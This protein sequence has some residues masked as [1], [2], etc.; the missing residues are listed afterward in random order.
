MLHV[1]EHVLIGLAIRGQGLDA[2]AYK[3]FLTGGPLPSPS[4]SYYCNECRAAFTALM[5]TRRCPEGHEVKE[6]V[7]CTVVETADGVVYPAHSV[8]LSPLPENFPRT[9]PPAT[10]APDRY[11]TDQGWPDPGGPASSFDVSF[12]SY[13]AALWRVGA[14]ASSGG[15]PPPDAVLLVRTFYNAAGL[16]EDVHT[17]FMNYCSACAGS[18]PDGQ[19]RVFGAALAWAQWA[20]SDVVGPM[21]GRRYGSLPYETRQRIHDWVLR[22]DRR[23][24]VIQR[25]PP[26]VTGEE[27]VTRSQRA[28][29]SQY[30]QEPLTS[31]TEER[32]PAV[33]SY[34]RFLDDVNAHAGHFSAPSLFIAF[35]RAFLEQLADLTRSPSGTV[36]RLVHASSTYQHYHEGEIV[37][38]L[39]LHGELSFFVRMLVRMWGDSPAV[40][41]GV[42]GASR[43]A[44]AYGAAHALAINRIPCDSV[45]DGAGSSPLNTD[46]VRA[47]VGRHM[48]FWFECGF[49]DQ[50]D[51]SCLTL[52]RCPHPG[53]DVPTAG[54]ACYP[55]NLTT[56][57]RLV[58]DGYVLG[59]LHK[60]MSDQDDQV[61]INTIHYASFLEEFTADYGHAHLVENLIAASQSRDNN[62]RD[63]QLY[64]MAQR[65]YMLAFAGQ[66]W[67][68]QGWPCRMTVPDTGTGNP[69]LWLS[70][71]AQSSVPAMAYFP[72]GYPGWSILTTPPNVAFLQGYL[73]AVRAHLLNTETGECEYDLTENREWDAELLSLIHATPGLYAQMVL[74]CRDVWQRTAEHA[75]NV[76][77]ELRGIAFFYRR[78]HI[79]SPEVRSWWGDEEE[80]SW[81]RF[82]E[83][84]RG[85][86]CF[87]FRRI[88]A[89]EQL[90]IV[91]AP[92]SSDV[93]SPAAPATT[94]APVVVGDPFASDFLDGVSYAICAEIQP[95]LPLSL[96]NWVEGYDS[97]SAAGCS[98]LEDC[99][100]AEDLYNF[101]LEFGAAYG[102]LM[103]TSNGFPAGRWFFAACNDDFSADWGR[104]PEAASL[105]RALTSRQAIDIM[106]NYDEAEQTWGATLL[107][108]PVWMPGCPVDT[109]FDEF[110][111]GY[112]SCLAWSAAHVEDSGGA[113]CPF[114]AGGCD[115]DQVA[116]VL[117]TTGE[118]AE[119]LLE[120]W[121]FYQAH[122]EVIPDRR[123]SE[124]GHDFHLTRNGHGAGFWDGD[125]D[126]EPDDENGVELA[127]RL[128]RAS[129]AANSCNLEWEYAD[130]EADEYTQEELD[131]P[132]TYVFY[133]VR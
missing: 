15:A 129:E 80:E 35:C 114:F 11:V 107:D 59:M 37:R 83:I 1:D 7:S 93:I 69:W 108:Y 44:A 31:T 71:R 42:P 5:P 16:M 41:A 45:A 18:I 55:P 122:R 84:C 91:A 73:R 75:E 72:T 46:M 103:D 76:S 60:A 124:A 92:W 30:Q 54:D 65:G 19:E 58:W 121:R 130:S 127:V 95:Q 98:A 36:T 116:A 67:P 119:V 101:C 100:G 94:T 21:L 61:E 79:E 109:N 85:A 117:L 13:L 33:A 70:K 4:L 105:L 78:N 47:N 38:F 123:L 39:L 90:D 34:Q 49:N 113:D 82:E 56:D 40:L 133:I 2:A 111:R 9:V 120:A 17:L 87:W 8:L 43:T 99:E 97:M 128:T 68:A 27:I 104:D 81:Q 102:P 25:S 132:D 88:P 64:S 20:E 32:L 74:T 77:P 28:Y 29:E 110:W 50:A 66:V 24:L 6:D 51:Y 12:E 115:P 126:D 89:R 3:R 112:L 14:T 26:A 62:V 10:A 63:G 48:P 131:N 96:Q 125:W 22:Y 118:F 86:G 106:V 23:R 57:A 53:A 52:R